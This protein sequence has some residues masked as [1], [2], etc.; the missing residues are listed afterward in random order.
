M[1]K[2]VTRPLSDDDFTIELTQGEKFIGVFN[3]MFRGNSN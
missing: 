1:A 2:F 3:N